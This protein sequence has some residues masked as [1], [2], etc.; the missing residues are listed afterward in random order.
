MA[1]A[2]PPKQQL[3][4]IMRADPDGLTAEIYG[5]L[6]AR[7]PETRAMFPANM[8]AQRAVLSDVLTH[9]L[10]SID[11]P[12]AEPA[13]VAFLR[14]LGKDHR[15]YGV[16]TEH[17]AAFAHSMVRALLRRIGDRRTGELDR[18]VRILVRATTE[19]M[20]S[21]AQEETGPP[22]VEATVVEHLRAARDQA[23]VRLQA[24]TPV[25]Y[26][27]GQY[28]SVRI[29]RHGWRYL[30]PT[31]PPNGGGQIEFHIRAV[32]GGE[33]SGPAVSTTRVGDRWRIGAAHGSL[34]VDRDA[35]ADVL[36]IAGGSGIAP[37]RSLIVDLARF[38]DNPRV[39][40]FYGARY[41]G[42]LVEMP[43]L[44][45]LS[46][47]NPWLTVVPVSEEDRDPWWIDDADDRREL[48]MH[49]RRTGTLAEIVTSYGAW[50]DRK[51]LVSGSPRMIERT[52]TQLTAAGTPRGNIVHDP[53]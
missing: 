10:E 43:T 16:T 36:M 26:E 17:Y 2:D 3:L 42:E 30:S 45:R 7:R 24:D 9:V 50:G 44:W 4:E 37:L 25:T 40:L 8:A 20:N 5:H 22:Y 46:L 14:Q 18:L 28:L 1:P 41:P 48:G 38:G 23:I 15:K 32:T 49:A 11:V 53:L 52:V 47:T 21:A 31:I 19:L 29:G 12:D 33:V 39:H 6:F 51:V 35:D 34:H 27:A 13:V